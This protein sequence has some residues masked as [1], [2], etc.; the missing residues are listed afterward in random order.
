MLEYATTGVTSSMSAS[1]NIDQLGQQSQQPVSSSSHHHLQSGVL[2]GG[3]S[4]D[5]RRNSNR[6]IHQRYSMNSL[7]TNV[8]HQPMSA[9]ESQ[10]YDRIQLSNRSPS[11]D[12]GKSFPADTHSSSSAN[13]FLRWLGLAGNGHSKK[14]E[15]A[16]KRRMSTY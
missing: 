2:G 6:K 13:R 11:T 1:G 15:A 4:S 9:R 14:Q 5:A 3:G 10:S 8:F 12:Y 7:N 16:E